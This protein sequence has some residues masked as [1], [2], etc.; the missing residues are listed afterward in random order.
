MEEVE[1]ILPQ[2]KYLAEFCPESG[3]ILSIGPYD[4]LKNKKNITDID[5][6]LV[7]RIHTGEV[8]IHSCFLNIDKNDVD[9]AETKYVFAID[10]VLHRISDAKY[11]QIENPDIIV[12]KKLGN[13]KIRLSE[14]WGGNYPLKNKKKSFKPRNTVWSGNTICEFLITKPNDPNIIYDYFKCYLEDIKNDYEYRL[15]NVEK[16]YSIYTKRILEKYVMESK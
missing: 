12:E 16:E 13:I 8:N 2:I 14:K 15:T 7:E 1:I 11:A 4:S 3:S 5:E 9:I 10:D 6:E